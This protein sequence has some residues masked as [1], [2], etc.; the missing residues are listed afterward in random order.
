VE[1]IARE[2]EY[3][4]YLADCR[5]KLDVIMGDARLS[6]VNGPDR[7]F[8]LLIIDVFNSDAVPLHLVT[9]EAFAVYLKHLNDRGV[10]AAH[11]SSRY[12]NLEPALARLAADAG[13][14]ARICRDNENDST[15]AITKSASDWVVMARNAE[16]LGP[17]TA[18]P[19]WLPLSLGKGRLWTDDFSN[20]VDA[21][22]MDNSWAWLQPS[23]WLQSTS[24]TEQV[25]IANQLVREERIDEAIVCLEKAIEI[26][27]QSAEA[28]DNLG[29]ALARLGK[30]DEAL[31]HY[32]KSLAIRPNSARTHN[33]LA[34][35]LSRQKR[36]DEAIDHFVKALEIDPQSAETYGSFG[37]ALA[38]VGRV[39]DACELYGKALEIQPDWAQ[40]HNGLAIAL[41]QLGKMGEA[42]PHWQQAVELNP[43]LAEAYQNWGVFLFIQGNIPQAMARWRQGIKEC[44]DHAMLLCLIARTLA[45]SWD[46]ALR[47]GP[48]AVQLAERA[49]QLSG[50]KN[51]TIL[52]VLASAYA[53]AGRFPES[54]ETA[55]RALAAAGNNEAKIAAIQA[56]LK[57]YRAG[58]AFHEEKQP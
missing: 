19:R 42:V 44:P 29:T 28:H 6:L 32:N 54:V 36:I 8:D 11:I 55:Q 26:D 24:A 15:T 30:I 2:P 12:L 35:T 13:L 1:R 57:L 33:N 56:K 25:V 41:A 51:A 21:I 45:T 38:G 17:L 48:E 39:K 3:F 46:A 14:I 20:I 43:R 23:S 40:M 58:S 50:G 7:K 27:P 22:Q 5:A 49:N 9:R 47:N 53:E 52:D 4:S 37:D 18:D 34:I 16:D 31:D 10:L